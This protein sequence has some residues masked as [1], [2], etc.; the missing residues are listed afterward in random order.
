MASINLSNVIDLLAMA[1]VPFWG[2]LVFGKKLF[3]FSGGATGDNGG[4]G[5]SQN[6]AFLFST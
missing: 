1:I 5:M 4:G 2:I 3:V 6:R